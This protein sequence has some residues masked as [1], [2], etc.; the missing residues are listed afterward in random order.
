M[1]INDNRDGDDAVG[2]DVSEFGTSSPVDR[3]RGKMPEKI[4]EPGDSA[5]GA[6]QP[7]VVLLL[8]GANARQDRHRREQRVEKKRSH[9]ACRQPEAARR[10]DRGGKFATRAAAHHLSA[11]HGGALV[12]TRPTSRDGQV[13]VLNSAFALLRLGMSGRPSTQRSF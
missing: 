1:S 9:R 7:L 6:Q 3:P 5:I 10:L 11:A 13:R 12:K 4:D 8:L 2:L